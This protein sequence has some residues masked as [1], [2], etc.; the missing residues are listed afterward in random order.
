MVEEGIHQHEAGQEHHEH[1]SLNREEHQTHEHHHTGQKKTKLNKWAV[2]SCILIALLAISM[3]T[4]WLDFSFSAKDKVTNETVEFI[5]EVFLKGQYTVALNSAEEKSGMYLM[6]LDVKGQSID[7]YVT[8]DGKLFFP[9][10]IDIKAVKEASSLAASSPTSA[11]EIKS[12]A[13]SDKPVVELFIMTHCPFGTQAEKGILPALSSIGSKADVKI[14][15]VH[16]F[17]H[18]DK[19]EQETYQQLCI[20]EEQKDKFVKYLQCFLEASDSAGC[21]T[22]T[23]IDKTKL[24]ACIK[25]KAKAYY[26]ADSELSKKYG[27]QGSPT[28]VINGGQADFYPR[29]ADSAL[30]NICGAFNTAPS[31]C[32]QKLSTENPSAGFGYGTAGDV[33]AASCG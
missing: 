21:L 28:L 12:V 29:S 19:E 32:S 7:T 4:S 3:F 25:D 20:R 14:R 27:V 18:G 26:A 13:K 17:M 22:K 23:G 1:L 5:N 31:E 15:F 2:F 6:K 8:K 11:G 16:Y 9:Q 24:D 10:A 30:K 33:A